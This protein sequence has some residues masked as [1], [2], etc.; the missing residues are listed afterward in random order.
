MSIVGDKLRM[1]H[2]GQ[3][4]IEQC[5]MR[6]KT[7]LVTGATSGIGFETALGL[8]RKGADVL[9]VARD[10]KR[11]ADAAAQIR[12]LAPQG[13]AEV[14][15][16]NLALQRDVRSL[17]AA[18][19]ARHA[20][21]DVLVNNAATV[22]AIRRVTEDGLE[23]SIA[24]NHLAPFLLTNLLEEPLRKATAAR[25]V[26][27]TSYLHKMVKV[28]PWDDL[29]REH[30]YDSHRAYNLTKLMNVLF[31]YELAKRWAGITVNC[32][33]PGWPL[34][35]NLGREERGP[36]RIFDRL[37]KIF[38]VSADRGAKTSICLASSPN[39]AN[40]SGEYYVS[41]KP[42]TSSRLSHDE[43]AG[44]RLWQVS[45]ELCRRSA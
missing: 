12:N 15:V 16:A 27:V 7:C 3:R 30:A 35:T 18:V 5:N 36:A 45:A 28:I 44:T 21:L 22:S 39:V 41:C 34:K 17:A 2:S 26:N 8:A 40:A 24:T 33:H 4:L 29:Q 43:A 31:T 11:G 13:A 23:I 32:L 20:R 19:L 37:S 42:A 38:A 9:M 25:V 14:F 6:G 10:I 1:S